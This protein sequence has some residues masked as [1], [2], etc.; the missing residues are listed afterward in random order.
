M[1]A[2]VP[3]LRAP[4]CEQYSP[5]SMFTVVV[6]SVPRL[7]QPGRIGGLTP[8]WELKECLYSHNSHWVRPAHGGGTRTGLR[9]TAP[10]AGTGQQLQHTHAPTYPSDA[11]DRAEVARKTLLLGGGIPRAGAAEQGGAAPF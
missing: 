8:G 2:H 7:P 9:H 4:L 1:R 11:N 5:S 6:I 10:A 3:I